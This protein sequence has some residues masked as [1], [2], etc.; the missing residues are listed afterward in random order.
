MLLLHKR[1][2]GKQKQELGLLPKQ[3]KKL[4]NKPSYKHRNNRVWLQ[5]N[6]IWTIHNSHHILLLS[7]LS[8]SSNFHTNHPCRRLAHQGI[9]AMIHL[10]TLDV[11]YR[12]A[13]IKRHHPSSNR[14]HPHFLG[15]KDPA[16]LQALGRL[17]FHRHRSHSLKV[18]HRLFLAAIHKIFHH[19]MIRILPPQVG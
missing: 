18:L 7:S 2:T 5:I 10:T 15:R 6:H 12:T 3:H 8:C 13:I 14:K 16:Q 11:R 9:M 1:K 17:Q 4:I 19:I